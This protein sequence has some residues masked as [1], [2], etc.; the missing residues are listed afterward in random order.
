MSAIKYDSQKPRMDLLPLD[1]LEGVA[2]VLQFGATKYGDYNFAKGMK[3]SRLLAA[4]LRHIS[5][6]Q[7]GEDIDKESGLLHLNHA[8]C[9]LIFLSFYEKYKTGEDDR[10]KRG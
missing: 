5:S 6:F 8:I 7:R 3:Y 1:V 9:S 10:C 4:T 2:E